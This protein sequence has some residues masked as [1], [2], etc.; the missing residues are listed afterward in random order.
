MLQYN[1]LQ[2]LPS[3][4]DLPES[5]NIPV[6]SELQI[7]VPSLLGAIL[8]WLWQDRSDWFWGVNMGVYHTP[9]QPAIVP[10]GFLSL[11]VERI[12]HTRGRL[13]YVLWEENN[14]IPLLALEFVSKTYGQE[15]D[16]KKTDY[17]QIGILYYVVYNPEYWTRDKHAP[18]EVYRLVEGKYVLQSGVPV[19]MP[20]IGL[21]L[22][23]EQGTYQAWAREW[24]YWYDQQG[25]RL[26]APEEIAQQ[27]H[28]R[29][30]QAEQQ[31]DSLIAKLRERGIDPDT[32]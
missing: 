23:R 7:L 27:E 25:K 21:G 29:A 16:D 5:D 20:E 15:Y 10:D 26:P 4:E 13:S 6:D 1:S 17:A 8:A 22:G 31:L 24:L 18:F 2:S 30:Q 12:N 3:A 11:G 9:N 19:W 28:Q 32:L 14:I